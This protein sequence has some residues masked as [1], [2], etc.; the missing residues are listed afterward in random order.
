M[1][2][3]MKGEGVVETYKAAELWVDCGLR[4]DDSLFTPGEAIWTTENLEVLHK[5][6]LNSP[7][8]TPGGFLPK[9]QGQLSGSPP[10]AYQL[11]GEALYVHYLIQSLKPETKR[12]RI[13]TVLGWV[14]P[15]VSI[16]QHLLAGL[17]GRFV[18]TG[19]GKIQITYQIGTLIESVEQWKELGSTE[20]ERLILDPWA[21][22]DFLFTRRFS[23]KLLV[24]NQDTG[25]L[26][27]HLLLHIVHPDSFEAMLRD[28]KDSLSKAKA[29]QCF[30]T[31]QA[32]D[33]DRAIK[34]IRDGL[35]KKLGRDFHFYRDDIRPY[36][37]PGK[38]DLVIRE[39]ECIGPRFKRPTCPSSA[40]AV[41][42]IDKLAKELL[43]E[44]ADLQNIVDGLKDKGQ[45]IFQGPP[46]TG[47]TFVAKRIGELA[48]EHSGD[49]KIVQ[50]HPSYS[51][52]DFVEGYR[53][54]LVN[55]NQAG[56]E[57]RDGPLKEIAKKAKENDKATFILVIDE[58][59][60]TNV[61]KV[62]GELYF[63][64]E[65]REDKAPLLYSKEDFD[66]P[67]NLWI[68]GTMNTTDRSIAL[69]D[70]ALR[71]RF[72]F[73]DFFPDEPPIEGLLR[74]WLEKNDVEHVGVADLVDHVNK[75]LEDRHLSIGPS[76]FMKKGRKLDEDRVRF[77]WERAVFPYIEEQLFDDDGKLKQFRFEKLKPLLAGR[78]ITPTP[79]AS[80]K[81]NGGNQKNGQ[82]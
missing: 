19:G 41:E 36:W 35:E 12:N 56:F 52:E 76:H 53:P 62:L 77:I 55:G 28:D 2:S 21:F 79:G 80:Q 70:A 39:M 72:Y 27:R 18:D 20:R 69:V 40:W 54:T 26:E 1:K 82:S 71:R 6:F 23:G 68:I 32:E 42:N 7:D 50:F 73:Y 63:L 57:L 43:W 9:L 81:D 60:R 75:R 5:K 58:I 51:Y 22:K 14:Q 30:V 34:Q 78:D 46:G 67:K 65:Y 49:Y 17:E 38:G 11:M 66:L 74:R 61:S 33:A 64:L 59:N 25:D 10:E 16:P 4:N 3:R 29:F 48:K 8:E 15:S 44:S 31:E 37:K 45:V 13:E 24:N 47:K